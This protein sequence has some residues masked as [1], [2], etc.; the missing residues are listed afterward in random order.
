MLSDEQ[1]IAQIRT[2][3]RSELADLNPPAGLLDRLLR[4]LET[5]VGISGKAG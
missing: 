4:E 2:E 5:E 1:L 3:L